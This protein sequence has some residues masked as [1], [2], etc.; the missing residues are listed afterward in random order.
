MRKI[1]FVI[2]EFE[3]G[4]PAQHL[5][6][7]FLTGYQRDGEFVEVKDAVITIKS[8]KPSELLQK[9]IKDH[10]LKM[11]DVWDANAAVVVDAKDLARAV[12]WAQPGTAL[13]AYGTLGASKAEANQIMGAASSHGVELLVGTEIATALRVPALQLFGNARESLIVVNGKFPTAEA[14]GLEGI[15]SLIPQPKKIRGIRYW[16]GASVWEAGDRRNWSLS[17]LRAALSRSNSPQGNAV[18]DGRTEDL[19]RSGLVQTM[20]RNPRAW[21]VET[22]GGAKL[23]A[24]VLDGVVSDTVAAVYANGR[25]QSTQFFQAPAPAREDFSRLVAVIDDFLTAKKAPWSIE[26]SLWLVEALEEFGRLEN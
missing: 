1:C 22:E 26:R 9:R 7:R 5:L 15:L 25:T 19:V 10:G 8:E 24:L 16:K 4:S 3:L 14:R 11:G 13:Y 17:L 12:K 18:L 6:D 21:V 20:A 23:E 2:D